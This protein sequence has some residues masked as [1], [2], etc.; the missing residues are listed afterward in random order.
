MNEEKMLQASR[1]MQAAADEMSRAASQFNEAAGH[2]I[3]QFSVML[4]RLA[5]TLVDMPCKNGLEVSFNP[6]RI[7]AVI[8]HHQFP[9]ERTLVYIDMEPFDVELPVSE[10]RRRLGI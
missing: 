5:P 1:N 3:T 4:D 10:V 2:L 6:N 7:A 8:A 9:E